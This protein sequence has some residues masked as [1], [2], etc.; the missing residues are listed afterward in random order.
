MGP[1][2]DEE[3]A[4]DEAHSM[5]NRIGEEFGISLLGIGQVEWF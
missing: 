5:H 2:A 4:G 1:E 3:G